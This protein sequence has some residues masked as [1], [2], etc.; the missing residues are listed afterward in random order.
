M[1]SLAGIRMGGFILKLTRIKAIRQKC[2]DCSDGILDRKNCAYIDCPLYPFR[3]GNK[4]KGIQPKKAIM[5]YCRWC[6]ITTKG[7]HVECYDRDCPLWCQV[8][9]G[10]A[11]LEAK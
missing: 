5:D 11:I 6:T 10:E 9:R 2:I 7:A 3:M 4:C 1:L 8:A